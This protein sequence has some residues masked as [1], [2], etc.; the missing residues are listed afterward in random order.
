MLL[1]LDSFFG[2][3]N[4]TLFSE[5]FIGNLDLDIN[6]SEIRALNSKSI[7]TNYFNKYE[8]SFSGEIRN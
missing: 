5:F 1:D 3:L 6:D 2:Y 4:Y 8:R 7:S